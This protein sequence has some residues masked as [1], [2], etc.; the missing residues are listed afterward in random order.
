MKGA[1]GRTEFGCRTRLCVQR[2]TLWGGKQMRSAVGR[3]FDKYYQAV[4][5]PSYAPGAAQGPAAAWSHPGQHGGQRA[6]PSTAVMEPT[7]PYQE[8]HTSEAHTKAFFLPQPLVYRAIGSAMFDVRV[9]TKRHFA[10]SRPA[11]S[12][13]TLV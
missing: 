11:S 4:P 9:L 6:R 3:A 13:T 10:L 8:E 12:L 1:A 2:R 7:G 5:R